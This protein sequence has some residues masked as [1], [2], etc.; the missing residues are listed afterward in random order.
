MAF[1]QLR[2]ELLAIGIIFAASA[3]A[4]KAIF[5]PES[6]FAVLRTV[7]AV[8]WLFVLPG[9]SIMLYWHEELKF[10]ERLVIGI[11]VGTSII[12]LA[13]YYLGLMGLHIKYHAIL[14]PSAMIAIGLIMAFNKKSQAAEN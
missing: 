9:F 13:S 6:F 3:I 7:L 11:A 10:F 1:E 12:G 4:F 2:K 5:F 14:L 8:F